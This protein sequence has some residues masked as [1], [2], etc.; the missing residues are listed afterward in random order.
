VA[1]P[2]FWLNEEAAKLEIKGR[3]KVGKDE[4]LRRAISRA[5]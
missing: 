1:N 4:L 3:S 2:L 5:R